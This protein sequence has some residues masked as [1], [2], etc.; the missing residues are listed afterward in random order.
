VR[1]VAE[2]PFRGHEEAGDRQDRGDVVAAVQ[3]GHRVGVLLRLDHEDAD[4]RGQQAERAGHEREEHDAHD[5]GREPHALLLEGG[6]ERRAEDHG[7]DV[8]GGRGLEQVRAAAGAVADVVADEICDDRRV[9]GVV[10][11]DARLDLADEVRADVGRLGVDAAA[12]LCEERHEG[13]AEA[14]AD[15]EQRDVPGRHVGEVADEPVKAADAE[16]R[17][18]DDEEAR[19]GASPQ[20]DP[21]GVVQGRPRRGS[22]PDVGSDRDPHA[23]VAGDHRAGRAENEGKRGPEGEVH[24]GGHGVEVV[25]SPDEP[26]QQ[27]HHDGQQD[28]QHSDRP[29]LAAQEG[30]RTLLDGVRDLL[31]GG[32]SGVLLEDP[33]GQE[34]GHEERPDG[35]RQDERQSQI[36]SHSSNSC[37]A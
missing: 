26:V 20:G 18:R 29:V 23:D 17:H 19:D 28:G 9:A 31:H 21:E 36:E 10:L 32:R 16:E 22:R 6:G 34:A 24:G 30:F 12:E 8:L 7:A 4:D 14:V 3:G 25:V 13:G 11:G 15:D 37:F 1:G 27:E 33:R 35:K 2:Q 5:S